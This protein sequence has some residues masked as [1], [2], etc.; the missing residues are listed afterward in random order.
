MH[1]LR[2]YEYGRNV[3]ATTQN[4][5]PFI[6]RNEV[7]NSTHVWD[8]LTNSVEVKLTGNGVYVCVFVC[9]CIRE[10]TCFKKSKH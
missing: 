1:S 6:F 8:M 3:A 5:S 4:T 9:V 10:K 2:V 7:N